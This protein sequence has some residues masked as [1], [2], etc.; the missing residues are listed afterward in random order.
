MAL[1]FEF[2]TSNNQ[3]EYEALVAGLL[4]ARDMGVENVLC[5][6]DSQLSVGQVHGEYQVKDPFVNEILS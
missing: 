6:T 3:A 5:K 4:L 1:R 2:K